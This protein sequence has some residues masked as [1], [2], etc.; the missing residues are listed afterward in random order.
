MAGAPTFAVPREVERYPFAMG[1]TIAVLLGLQL[2]TGLLLAA[3]YVPTTAQARASLDLITSV[4]AYGW[5]LR[6]VHRAAATLTVAA[7]LL[8]LARTFLAGAYRAP[9]QLT[10]LTGVGL[11][12]LTL[13]FG[14][15]GYAL[16]GDVDA[17]A[18]TAVGLRLAG[19]LGALAG[20][21]GQVLGRLYVVH[22]A[23][24]PALTLALAVAHVALVRRHAPAPEEPDTLPYWPDH[25]RFQA[26]VGL[27][28]ASL[29]LAAA[30]AFP[31]PLGAAA[32]SHAAAA[33][34]PRPE[35]YF[36]PPYA[37]LKGVPGGA[38]GPLLLGALALLGAWPWLEARLHRGPRT[39]TAALA[40]RAA[41]IFGPLALALWE[42]LT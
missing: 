19:P 28:A 14:F 8:H 29:V 39:A 11:L 12:V 37:L 27:V 30:L 26:L 17:A 2:M 23:A 31:P 21:P 25:A 18:A 10:W 20:R 40:L 42:A 33:A 41:I 5:L 36:L 16:V 34:S 4:A 6:G 13:A 7:V 22:V 32:G 24:L 1:G 9:R 38:A 15:T 35:W 3:R